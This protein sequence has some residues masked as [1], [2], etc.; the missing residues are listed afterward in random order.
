[1]YSHYILQLQPDNHLTF[2]RALSLPVHS[3]QQSS[4]DMIPA[5]PTILGGRC[6]WSYLNCCERPAGHH[7]EAGPQDGYHVRHPTGCLWAGVGSHFK[8]QTNDWQNMFSTICG[9]AAPSSASLELDTIQLGL[10]AQPAVAGARNLAELQLRIYWHKGMVWWRKCK[11]R[12]ASVGY[13]LAR[14]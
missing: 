3:A 9:W 8:G 2:C 4:Q 11:I 6:W 5:D 12:L 10:I 7:C 1:M 14:S 13:L